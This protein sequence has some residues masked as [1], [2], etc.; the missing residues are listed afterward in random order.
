MK[1]ILVIDDEPSVLQV[2][3]ARLQ[4]HGF[5]VEI[6]D[7][8]REGIQKAGSQNPD[9]ILLDITMPGMNGF[10]TLQQLKLDSK[11]AGIPV[12]MLSAAGET[13]NIFEAEKLFAKDFVIKPFTSEDLLS[14]IHRNI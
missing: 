14:V 7:T 12:V 3:K 4:A 2:I 10:Q 6:A 13:N 9:L 8:A 1:K 11:T 5:A